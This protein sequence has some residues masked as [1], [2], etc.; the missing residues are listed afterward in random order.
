MKKQ[1]EFLDIVLKE[2]FRVVGDTYNISKTKKQNW[3]WEH[4]W[5]RKQED[6]FIKW[7]SELLYNNPDARNYFMSTPIKDKKHCERV[8]REFSCYYG[9]KIKL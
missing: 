3:Y 1:N 6:V 2:M 7:F 4:E 9:W 5:T 8:A